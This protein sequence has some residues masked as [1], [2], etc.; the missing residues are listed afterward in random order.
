MGNN[1]LLVCA[2]AFVII[3]AL[4]LIAKYIT[5]ANTKRSEY[6]DMMA[7]L[8]EKERRQAEADRDSRAASFYALQM[9]LGTIQAQANS[10]TSQNAAVTEAL[11]VSVEKLGASQ[12]IMENL[13]KLQARAFVQSQEQYLK[14]KEEPKKRLTSR[15]WEE[16]APD[17]LV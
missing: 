15:Y 1:I 2:I 5:D 14:A 11:R 13:A 16:V 4:V 8:A 9:T 6:A 7:L 3:L 17:E 10:L 12:E